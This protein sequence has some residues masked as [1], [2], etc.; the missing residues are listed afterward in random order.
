[1]YRFE[2]D[3]DYK[4]RITL[5]NTFNLLRPGAYI[6]I[7]FNNKTPLRAK[8]KLIGFEEGNFLIV[9]LSHSLLRDYNDIIKEG[10][11]CIIRT[12][13]EGEAGQCVAFRAS[14]DFVSFRPK[15]LLF[16]SYPRKV[17]TSNL[18]KESRLTTQLPVTFVYR[19]EVSSE[20]LFD[21]KTAVTGYIK[22]ISSG[23][24]RI[25]ANWED[26]KPEINKVPVYLNVTIARDSHIILKAEIRNKNRINPTT[27]AIGLSFIENENLELFLKEFTI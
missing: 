5:V 18:R 26:S 20:V 12:I 2:E 17:E 25:L 9:S 10:V 24:C 6:D 8:G 16:I 13:I 23:G 1:M 11:G 7:E 3:L 21:N 19:D 15:G 14:I 22:D 27:V 4:E